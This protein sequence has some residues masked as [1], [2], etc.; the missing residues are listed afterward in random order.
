MQWSCEVDTGL[1][2]KEVL[3]GLVQLNRYEP[4]D[5]I[6]LD[7]I[8]YAFKLNFPGNYKMVWHPEYSIDERIDLVFA[9]EKD[10][11]EWILKYS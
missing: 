2:Y 10:E 3:Y 7:H 1:V 4:K 11:L 8:E 9:S 6:T 5:Q